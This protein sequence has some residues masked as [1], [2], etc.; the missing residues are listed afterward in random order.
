MAENF[1]E[2]TYVWSSQSG[3]IYPDKVACGR[4]GTENHSVTGSVVVIY[5]KQAIPDSSSRH[6]WDEEDSSKVKLMMSPKMKCNQN[7]CHCCK[8]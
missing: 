4:T 3:Q 7:K 8:F 1:S 2:D 6:S 5:S